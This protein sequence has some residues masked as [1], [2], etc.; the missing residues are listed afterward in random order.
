[1][2]EEHLPPKSSGNATPITIYNG[3]DGGLRVL[4]SYRRGHTVPS[5]CHACNGGASD[6][7]LPLAYATWRKDV[8][9]VLHRQATDL[10][11]V[12]GRD[13]NDIWAL[14][15]STT[16][17]Y[18]L[19]MEHGRGINPAGG[20]S[21]HPGRIVRQVIGMIL[22]VQKTRRLR[23]GHPELVA[24]YTSTGPAA[25]TGHSLHVALAD[26][27]PLAYFT[28]AVGAVTVDTT[29]RRPWKTTPFW[30]IAFPPFLIMLCEGMTP[31]LEAARIDHW[32]AYPDNAIYRKADRTTRYP[33]AHR[34]NL[35]VALL[36]SQFGQTWPAQRPDPGP[37]Q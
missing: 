37:D 9:G 7:G 17:A 4:R 6:R 32:L 2:T 28:D 36:N 27:G 1:M 20:V 31:P 30:A 18:W 11:P 21:M 12:P 19:T 5:L 15:T 35:F 8:L 23:D 24:A 14:T 3:A 33:I 29:G 26:T 22:A 34:N 25:L 13:H 10:P 16:E